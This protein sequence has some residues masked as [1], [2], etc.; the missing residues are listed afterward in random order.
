MTQ[1]TDFFPARVMAGACSLVVLL[2][3]QAP[4]ADGLVS[5]KVADPITVDGTSD[6]AWDQAPPLKLTLDKAPYKSDSYPGIAQ[7][8]VTLRSAYDAG[9]IYFVVQYKDPT[10]SLARFPWVKQEDGSWKQTKKLDS[11]GHENTYFEDKFAILW[12]VNTKGFAKLGCAIVC[13]MS[14]GGKV[15]GVA[16]SSP[17]RKYTN[18]PGEKVDMWSWEGVHSSAAGQFDDMF[19]NDNNPPDAADWG[20]RGDDSTGGGSVG[21]M[22]EAKTG[23]AFMSAK[24]EADKPWITDD[25]KVPFVDTF[26]AGDSVPSLIVKPHSGS[27]A[28]VSCAAKWADG[29]WT[30]EF[31][32]K[33]VTTGEKTAEQDVQFSDLTKA[34]SFGVA[35]FDNA[36]INHLYHGGS[37]KLTFK[38]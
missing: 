30:I 24:P 17:G 18:R 14:V 6:A 19:I 31:K 36:Q 8:E 29:V 7:T 5:V 10:K 35:V 21:N 16:D 11:S 9:D 25:Q 4:A 1:P 20:R 26:K 32:R 33:L 22:N 13:H 3:V 28:D 15:N 37:P 38:P 23:P 2:A 27:R 34:Y 12:D